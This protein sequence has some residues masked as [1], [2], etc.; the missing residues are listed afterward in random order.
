MCKKHNQGNIVGRIL[1][2]K[3]PKN[4]LMKSAKQTIG[5]GVMSGA[6][7]G[8]MGAMPQ[9]QGAGNISGTVG[10]SLGL[11]NTG[12]MATNAM[13]ITQMMHGGMK[14]GKYKKYLK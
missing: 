10:S 5:L 11:L 9:T 8:I 3:H 4:N 14:K 12:Q 13:G 1:G 7:M 2:E 6:G